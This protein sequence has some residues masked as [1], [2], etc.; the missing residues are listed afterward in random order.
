MKVYI[1]TSGEYSDYCIIAVTLDKDQAERMVNVFPRNRIEIYDTDDFPK[2][3]TNDPI[4][5]CE[6]D[7]PIRRNIM[8]DE[9]IDNES[10]EIHQEDDYW[11][12]Y[13]FKELNKVINKTRIN[14]SLYGFRMYI[15]AKDKEHVTKIFYDKIAEWKAEQEGIV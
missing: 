10:I 12:A 8:G 3:L 1:I 6:Y 13:D 4:W 2:I 9:I 11:C 7:L 15:Q 14:G 5:I